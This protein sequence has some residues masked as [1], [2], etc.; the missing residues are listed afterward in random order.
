MQ[1]KLSTMRLEEFKKHN[2]PQKV[3]LPMRQIPDYTYHD[4]CLNG[5]TDLP[6]F[7][8]E[9]ELSKQDESQKKAVVKAEPRYM[10]MILDNKVPVGEEERKRPAIQIP[11]FSQ[12][13]EKQ[14]LFR[15]LGVKQFDKNEGVS[16]EEVRKLKSVQTRDPSNVSYR[17]NFRNTRTFPV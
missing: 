9:Y 6:K 13:T 3:M 12:P 14:Q 15:Q 10:S 2:P 4:F 17:R 16:M 1:H 11:D 8:E 7:L 5:R